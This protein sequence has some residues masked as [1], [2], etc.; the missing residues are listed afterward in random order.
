MAFFRHQ[1]GIVWA[2]GD[3]AQ[4]LVLDPAYTLIQP[5]ELGPPGGGE[6]TIAA[7][8]AA[9]EGL[10]GITATY[11]AGTGKIELDGSGVTGAVTADDV[12]ETTGRVWFIPAERAKLGGID[13]GATANAPDAA[14]RDRATHTGYQAISTVS[15]LQA[16][17]DA[18]SGGGAVSSVAGMTGDV[19]LDTTDIGGLSAALAAKA[20]TASPTFTGSVTIPNGSLSAHA[21]AWG[22]VQSEV[23]GF[24]G[25][26]AVAFNIPASDDLSTS[27]AFMELYNDDPGGADWTI[28]GVRAVVAEAPTG[29]SAVFDV[30]VDG[31]TIF[32]GGTG[33]PTVAAGTRTGYTSGM[34][35]T[36]W[37]NGS[38]CLVEV[39]QVGSTTPGK[40][41]T[42][43]IICSPGTGGGGGGATTSP[44]A[45]PSILIVGYDMPD[46]L[47]TYAE[48]AAPSGLT[49]VGT[50]INDQLII[51]AALAR[52]TLVADGFGGEGYCAVEL[53]GKFQTA[54]N[55]AQPIQLHPN[56]TLK[57]APW[58]HLITPLPPGTTGDDW[59]CIELLNNQVAHA[60]VDGI[61]VGRENMVLSKGHGIKIAQSGTGQAYAVKTANDPFVTVQ[62][63]AFRKMAGHGVYATGTAGG[64]RETRIFD[65]VVYNTGGA[66][67]WV[68]SSSDCKIFGCV[69]A[70]C[71]TNGF[72]MGG[73][74][75]VLGAS[76]A[77]Y[78][79]DTGF[80]VTS[81]GCS[82]FGCDAQDNGIYGFNFTGQDVTATGLFADSNMRLSQSGAAFR[83]AA[84]GTYVGLNARDRNQTPGSRQNV[85][86]VFS[87]SP[88]VTIQ[89]R[90]L[91]RGTGLTSHVS[92][93]PQAESKGVITKGLI[94]GN[95]RTYQAAWVM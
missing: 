25:S 8:A 18:A 10:G 31:T 93:T 87:G 15:G 70:S 50:G 91:L 85:G 88:H 61:S 14:L 78:C 12:S 71:G 63:C 94:D 17:L 69:A 35:T 83:I 81:S 95:T 37:P 34:S 82:I 36:A 86:V 9:I 54:Q 5:E 30:L 49:V 90:V 51:N 13:S 33:R 3:L 53:A 75:T 72:V 28:H 39:A 66:G 73:G 64:A 11:N 16:A 79:V 55:G 43:S 22:Q 76:K 32:A 67:F 26:R 52:A 7:V 45:R 59:G 89:G 48:A 41:L 40:G 56:V 20:D 23:A 74:N 77:F 19:T 84:D 24:T 42:L 44:T 68:D 38:P 6:L 1:Y 46:S 21:A 2:V 58:G 92:G 65:C 80:H 4:A 60:T 27:G 29:S 57:S 47:K 62:N